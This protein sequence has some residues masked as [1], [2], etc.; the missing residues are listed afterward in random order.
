MRKRFSQVER[1]Q[2]CVMEISAAEPAR[3]PRVP[4]YILMTISLY[5][6][7]ASAGLQMKLIDLNLK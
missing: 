1:S 7:P 3:C 5:T 6:P 2:T 4:W